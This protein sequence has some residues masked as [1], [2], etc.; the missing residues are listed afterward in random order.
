MSS[1]TMPKC[2]DKFKLR[3]LER[4]VE[5]ERLRLRKKAQ[6]SD[7]DGIDFYL[8][9]LEASLKLK[10]ELAREKDWAY[11]TQLSALLEAKR[12]KGDDVSEGVRCVL[13]APMIPPDAFQFGDTSL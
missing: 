1:K 5:Q 6:E 13:P 11:I 2:L 7:L 9:V 10:P 12:V 8:F 3:E 4:K